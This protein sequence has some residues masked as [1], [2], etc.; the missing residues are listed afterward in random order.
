MISALLSLL[1]GV[2]VLFPFI[3]MILLLVIYRR[4]GKAP[5]TVIGHAADVTT[6][7]LFLSVYVVSRTIFG[8]GVGFYIAIVAIIITL[9]RAV[10]EKKRVKEFR[11]VRLL[12]K[13]WR[14]LFIVLAIAYLVLL[15]VG[16]MLKVWEYVK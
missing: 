7:F 6:P 13:V 15:V 9:I 3:I 8:E 5:A 4:L 12:R 14:L 2:I 1:V 10:F 11:I 16:M